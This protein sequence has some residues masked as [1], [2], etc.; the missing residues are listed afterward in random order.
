MIFKM[1]DEARTIKVFNLRSDT[2]EFIGAGDAYIA[3]NTGLPAHCTDIEPPKVTAGKVAV[4]NESKNSW[5]VLDDHRGKVVFDKNTA[6]SFYISEL[7]PLPDNV[8]SVSPD[9][10]Y[11][12]WGGKGWVKD[13]EAEKLAQ[14]RDAELTKNNLMQ[15]A[16]NNI[17]PLQDAVDLELATDEE[18]ELL[19]KWKKYRVLLNRVNVTDAPDITWPTL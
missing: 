3:P 19:N 10:E 8:T 11:Q 18:K 17:F 6:E 12:M 1:T 16:N 13:I 5:D 7:G 15:T 2:N 9:G 14:V 4:F